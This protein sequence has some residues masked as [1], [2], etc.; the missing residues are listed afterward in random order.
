LEHGSGQQIGGIGG[1]INSVSQGFRILGLNDLDAATLFTALF[2]A[3]NLL[4]FL[5]F[6]LRDQ[7]QLR[8]MMAISL[9][10]QALYYYA[11]PGGPFID[12]LFWKVVSFVANMVMIV[13]V[14]GGRIDFGIPAD[15]RGLFEKM[16]VLSPGQF[17]KLIRI[18]QRTYA[19]ENLLLVEGERPDHL[20]YLLKGQAE[21]AK[22]QSRHWIEAGVFLG[23]VAFLNTTTASA[24][25]RLLSS[26]ECVTWKTEDLKAMMNKDKAIDIAMR[27]IFNHDLAAKVAKSVPLKNR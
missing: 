1:S 3:S 13:L 16:A 23:E 12:P 27:G 4:A 24:T 8:V 14:F 22:G 11:I 10:L 15:L 2:H 9:F 19:S 5:A 17:R 25:V 7:L 26:A 21:I 6:L 18:S 20:H